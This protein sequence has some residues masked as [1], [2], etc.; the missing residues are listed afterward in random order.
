MT[1]RRLGVALTPMETRREIIVATALRAEELGY[2]VFSLA[3]G[4]AHDA[5]LLLT[6]IATRTSRISLVAGVLSVWSR[7]PAALAM[8]AVTLNEISG[9][10]AILGLGASSRALTEGLHDI[11]FERPAHQLREVASEVRNIL[12]GN[13]VSIEPTRQARA[14]RLGLAPAPDLPIWIAATGDLTTR[15]VADHADG[16]YPLFLTLERMRERAAE[17][18]QLRSGRPP[19]TITAGAFAAATTDRRSARDIV[20][21]CLA[22]YICAMGDGYADLIASQGYKD[23]VEAIRAANPR[24][25]P[26]GSVVPPEANPALDALTIYGTPTEVR[27]KLDTW[28]PGSD[29]QMIVLPAGIP[30]ETIEQTLEAVALPNI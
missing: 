17:L 28:A 15:I 7:T 6:E 14:L 2:E 30:W 18:R 21:S 4:W 8:S 3:E 16:W 11:A 10:R 29:I 25:T 23:A 12:A 19:L 27:E 1:A 20:A 24:P 26:T 13:R 9:G 22:W 5:T